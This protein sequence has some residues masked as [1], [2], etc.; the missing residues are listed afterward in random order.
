MHLS[1]SDLRFVVETVATRRRDYDHI[2]RLVR[3]KDDLI[4]PMLED[5]SLMERLQHDPTALVLASPRLM[6]AVLLR[7][8]RRDLAGQS[9]VLDRD[10]RG[11]RIP[12]FEAAQ[13]GQLLGEPP[14]REYLVGM[15]CSFVRTRSSLVCWQEGRAW[16]ERQLSDVDMDD[17]MVLC[18]LVETPF[19]P[20]L[21][22]RIADIALF[23]SGIYPQHAV[24]AG[25]SRREIGR[26]LPDYEREGRR[27]YTLAARETEPAG[28]ARVLESLS[29]KFTLAREAL[30]AL[31][32]HYLSPLRDRYFRHPAAERPPR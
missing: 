27:F 6:F 20:R 2:I 3:G 11:R 10:A 19:K 31:S 9:F 18:Q 22:Q 24:R 5:P 21:Y 30:N 28:T 26:T 25:R 13:A 14:L 8:V 32:D 16:R 17:M 15:L 1:E 7:R 12:V 23:L 29:E 4:E